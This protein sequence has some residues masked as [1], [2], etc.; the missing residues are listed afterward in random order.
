MDNSHCIDD[1]LFVVAFL[2]T[3]LIIVAAARPEY[4][5]G[6]PYRKA[7]LP[8]KKREYSKEITQELH[9]T[10]SKFSQIIFGRMD[11]YLAEDS[12]AVLE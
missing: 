3:S 2:L 9:I 4:R 11:G 1:I 6:L 10:T 12:P 5:C 7:K 8:R